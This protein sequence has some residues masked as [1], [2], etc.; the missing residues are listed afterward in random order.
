MSTNPNQIARVFYKEIV[1]GDLLK[2][3]AQSNVAASGGGARDL[4]IGQHQSLRTV[5]R[6]LFPASISTTRVRN[7]VRANEQI[8]HGNFHLKKPD[9]TVIVDT[10][11]FE[12]PT[13]AR[14]SEGRITRVNIH[15]C[16]SQIR[17]KTIL[18][19]DKLML[20]LVQN[21]DNSVW[22]YFYYESSFRTQGWD[23]KVAQT[24]LDCIGKTRPSNQVV[25]GFFD[26]TNNQSYCNGR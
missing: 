24:L 26:F 8:L 20:L 1:H 10:V 15:E 18:S 4:R 11:T 7:G 9:G 25:I 12:P 5:I 6:Q 14:P 2:F 23:P 3:Q 13:D 21:N 19:N 17:G 22:P 16:F